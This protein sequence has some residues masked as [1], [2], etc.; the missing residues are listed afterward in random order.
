MWLLKYKK[1]SLPYWKHLTICGNCIWLM[2][3]CWH[4]INSENRSSA[5]CN[6]HI[7]IVSTDRTLVVCC[8]LLTLLTSTCISLFFLR[9]LNT[10]GLENSKKNNN[11]KNRNEEWTSEEKKWRKCWNRAHKT[12]WKKSVVCSKRIFYVHTVNVFSFHIKKCVY[13]CIKMMYTYTLD[14]AFA[15]KSESN[16]RTRRIFYFTYDSF[17]S[18]FCCAFFLFSF[19]FIIFLIS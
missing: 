15:W 3:I 18:L 2:E 16:G 10:F 7:Y 17:F 6:I 12:K 1:Y 13:I 19:I 9:I 8:L 4:K 14:P 5:S 11:P